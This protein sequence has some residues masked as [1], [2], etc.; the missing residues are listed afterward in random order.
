MNDNTLLLVDDEEGIRKV[1]GI[2]LTDAG[3]H[4][5]TA[6]NGEEGLRIFKEA[7]PP[8][9]LTDIKMPGLDG[10][11]LL[12]RIKAEEPET[13]VIM[14]TGHGDMELAVKSL[15]FEATDFVTKPINDDVLEIALKRARE[16]ISMRREI[17]E[18]THHLEDLVR[19]KSEQLVKAER[20]AAVGQVVE[21]LSSALR[22]IVDDLDGDITFFN[23]MPCFV[24]IHNRDLNILA[25]N[26]LYTSRLGEFVGGH[27]W[28]VYKGPAANPALCPVAKTFE[29]GKGLRSKEIMVG[30][31]G[32]DLPVIVHTAPIRN[33][34]GEVELVLEISADITEVRRV[35]EELW[36]TQA[37]YLQLFEAAP[38]YI[39]VQDRDLRILEANRLYREDFGDRTGSF[40]HEVYKHRPESCPDC[41]VLATFQDGESHRMELLV[42]DKQ[43]RQS[44][45]LISTAPIWDANDQIVQVMELATNITEIRQL[46]SHLSNLGL[47]IGSISH[48]IK[49]LLTG[50]D[51]GMYMVESGFAKENSEQIMEGWQTVQLT[52]SRIRN[53][54]LDILYYAKERDLKWERVDVLS[55]VR[56]VALAVQH[57][58]QNQGVKFVKAF[59]RSVGQFEVDPGVVRSALI[60]FL[61]NAVDACVDDKVKEEHHVVF[62]VSQDENNI[63]F[64]VQDNGVGMDQETQENLFTLFFSSKGLRG[65]GLGLYVSNKIIRQ[66]GGAVEVDSQLGQGSLFRIILPKVLPDT[67]KSH[68]RT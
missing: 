33:S 52:V 26:Q 27:S 24:S 39:T 48:G 12:R 16:R 2:S 63:I 13:E 22:D 5:L 60:N 28:E 51:G 61:E 65:T 56:D 54:V 3:Y 11:E 31:G 44:E 46:Q 1:L 29:N 62:G 15:K 42:A 7:K 19:R 43:G 58:A 41:P 21:G 8:I 17:K 40:C 38:C 50:L 20:L 53:M 35:Q 14:I 59:D 32:E 23:E 68:P 64:E 36:D 37:K 10:L 18:Y 6:A 9:V 66:H 34:N 49:G 45:L 30:L 4:V 57:K 47:L 67:A 25:A 55:F